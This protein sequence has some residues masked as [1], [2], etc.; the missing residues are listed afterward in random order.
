M[1]IKTTFTRSVFLFLFFFISIGVSAQNVQVDVNLN[2]VHS[3]EGISDFGRDRHITVH[4]AATERDWDGQEDKLDYFIND[5]DVYWG[6]DNGAASWKFSDTPEDPNRPN[7]P[8]VSAMKFKAEELKN[9]YESKL[10]AKQYEGKGFMIQGTNPHPTYP[11]LDWGE[12]GK[13]W[14]GWQPLEV[15]TSAEWVTEYLDHY[16]AKSSGEKGEPLPDYWE[17]INEP[18]MEM[19]VGGKSWIYASSQEKLWEYHNLVAEGVKNRLGDKAPKIGGMT[20]GMHDFYWK[21]GINRVADNQYEQWFSDDLMPYLQEMTASTVNDT[22]TSDWYQWDVM[23]QGFIDN[24]GDNMDFYGIHIYDWSVGERGKG[25][26]RTGGHVEAMLDMLEWYDIHKFGK[27]KDIVLSE[28]GAVSSWINNQEMERKAWENLRPFNGMFMQFLER[29]S[30]V[31]YSMPFAPVKAEWGD[32]RDANGNVTTR[33]GSVLMD[34]VDP[35]CTAYDASCEWEWSDFVKW[36][37]LWRDVDGTRIDT[38]A[39]DRD[40]QVDAYVDN[41]K[42]YLIVNNLQFDEATVDLNIFD[43]EATK[44]QFVDKRYM[45]FDENKG[46]TGGVSLDETRLNTAPGSM[47]ISGG[48]TVILVYNFEKDVVLDQTS[49]EEKYMSVALNNETTAIGGLLFRKEVPGRTPMTTQIN[50]VVVPSQGEATLR[51]SGKFPENAMVPAYIT[52]N[53]NDLE[54]TT[55]WRGEYEDSRN[56]WFGTM[57]VDVPLEYLQESN[58]V[59]IE[60]RGNKVTY[61][62]VSLQVF[63]MSATPAR[64]SNSSNLIAL[65]DISI[66]NEAF[67]LMNGKY[68]ALEVAFTPE[69]ATNKKITWTSS[70]DTKIVVDEFGMLTSKA[71]AGEV[72]ITATS[73][74][75]SIV[76]TVVVTAVPYAST[77]ITEVSIAQGA[78]FK[79]E[80]NITTPLIVNVLPEGAENYEVVWSSS[81]EKAVKVDAFTGKIQGLTIG[82]TAKITATVVDTE[83]GG[84]V[85]TDDI[86]VSVMISGTEEVYC[87]EYEEAFIGN[88]VY[89]FD[90]GVNALANRTV[91][92]ELLKGST[93][94]G[95]AEKT[96]TKNGE[97]Y[98][99]ITIQLDQLAEIST[100][101]S[102]KLTLLDGSST[103]S[104]CEST[105]AIDAPILPTSI[106]VKDGL[107][108]VQVGGTLTI[109]TD[110]IPEN[111]F[112]KSVNW[113]IISGADIISIEN[114]VITGLK[115]G[116]AEIKGVANADNAVET[117]NLTITCQAEAV[118]VLP[119]E[120]H[121]AKRTT[122]FPN[123][124]LPMEIV[125]FVPDFTNAKEVN[126]TASN[127][128]VTIDENGL[129][130]AGNTEGKVTIT[131]TSKEA[132]SVST[133]LELTVGNVLYIEAE[134]FDEKFGDELG[135]Y[136]PTAGVKG[137]NAVK[138]GNYVVYHIYF[139]AEGDYSA[140]FFA[141]TAS[142][143]SK[144]D[145]YV[146][147]QL[148]GSTVINNN[149]WDNFEPYKL[150]E[151]I[152]IASAGVH[153]VG[154]VASGTTPYQWNLEHFELLFNGDVSCEDLTSVSLSENIT[155]TTCQTVQVTFSKIPST[156]CDPTQVQWSID[157]E[158]VTTIDENGQL[159]GVSVGTTTLRLT[160]ELGEVTSQVTITEASAPTSITI[161]PSNRTIA[162]G[163][164][165]QL[166]AEVLPEGICNAKVI[167]SS[168]NDALATVDATGLLEAQAGASGQTVDITA[169]SE[170][171]NTILGTATFT[172][173]SIAQDI[174][175]EAEDFD[176]TG[177]TFDDGKVPFGVNKAEGVGINWVNSGDYAEFDIQLE[178]GSYEVK[179]LISSPNDNAEVTITLNEQSIVTT[180]PNNGSWDAYQ[181][182][183]AD[184][185]I[186]ITNAGNYVLKIL[187]SGTQ[188]WQW[189]LDKIILIKTDISTPSS[190]CVASNVTITDTDQTLDFN[191]TFTVNAIVDY[192]GECTGEI[193]WSSSD[194]SVVTVD[195]NGK[196]T[197]IGAGTAEVVATST[198]GNFTDKI[199]FTVNQSTVVL[200]E[201]S[202]LT[203]TDADQTL[204]IDATF[205]VNATVD[206]T[207]DCTGEIIWS[208]SDESVVR[209]D[210]N[211]LVTAIGAGSAEVVASSSESELTAK[212]VITVNAPAPTPC[213]VTNVTIT[214]ADQ[215]LD[216]DGTFTVNAT[217]D[218]TGDCTGEITWSS[219]DESVVTVDNNGLVT[220]IGSGTAEVTA[221]SSEG[222]FSD[223]IVFTVNQLVE[224]VSVT[225]VTLPESTVNLIVD[226][227]HQLTATIT[228]ENATNLNHTWTTSDDKVVK[229]DELGMIT[230]VSPGTATI[231]VSTADGGFTASV[232]VTAEGAILSLTDDLRSKISAYPVPAEDFI[233]FNNLPNGRYEFT[234]SDTNGKVLISE[235]MNYQSGDQLNVSELTAGIYIVNIHNNSI[236]E[237]IKIQIK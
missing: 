92:A 216:V 28:F 46:T 111:A 6:R 130:V 132:P 171:D 100:D 183:K 146:D 156:A 182:L 106:T 44:V 188:Q 181:E 56:F 224:E 193:T 54:Y 152:T 141:G 27:K 163:G 30:Q 79:T 26:I 121:L 72:T 122:V 32:V 9:W 70:D 134:D 227:T 81:N 208:S 36:Y 210:N 126:W 14:H 93:V 150:T 102:L 120:I 158:G 140:T 31:V 199:V 47:T 217:I 37:E 180:V 41:N 233:Q 172:I 228:P 117:S 2:M 19:M 21:D 149:G 74:D 179:Y 209:V 12:R 114:G 123:S 128:L 112:D 127:D 67:D 236:H 195:N 110:V 187:A 196:V 73:E 229:V 139:P 161:L 138:T 142:A 230:A 165:L 5:L 104:T 116:T 25:V 39:T 213:V 166:S 29:P 87:F 207:G 147:S 98:L 99:P 43:T 184:G 60:I 133:S 63:D 48:G 189:N 65:T 119:T 173:T 215:T 101:Y 86:D 38:K 201:V 169:T 118:V 194:E 71:D 34:R 223:K 148:Q 64:S 50:N 226:G 105:L 151:T 190:S 170:V 178:A 68:E 59:T 206:Y 129:V 96:L 85:F 58:E 17:V 35:N 220:A 159:V 197:A 90:I 80:V 103:L 164:T 154:V 113:E 137:I 131:A 91:K 124:T 1:K 167:W 8:D 4:S 214:D 53:G 136:E 153:E 155:L 145:L 109:E 234:V 18:D 237:F 235:V 88:D 75:G 23:W 83:N 200:C 69:N 77:P 22:R 76:K 221:S 84:T 78:T 13:T 16:F 157:D 211:G 219:S 222:D 218:Y 115:A 7:K 40:I 212:I 94:L 107:R 95:D 15:E 185:S 202:N 135:I 174:V 55:D 3:V 231:T 143:D 160:T 176:R 125:G 33:Y 11:T 89:T 24:C 45:Y 51:F 66:T 52:V 61:T 175:I 205:T 225:G 62:T 42:V 97:Q 82:G 204:E 186:E 162:E 198:E 177:G 232:E 108:T 10:N 20:W 57:E 49:I 168:S 203:I 191:D 144:L 192:T